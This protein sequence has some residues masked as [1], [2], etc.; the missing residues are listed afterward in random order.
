MRSRGKVGWLRKAAISLFRG[1]YVPPGLKS[2]G[3]SEWDET[4]YCKTLEHG[5]KMYAWCLVQLNGIDAAEAK[6]RAEKRYPYQA[7]GTPYRGIIFHE[8][9][10][11]IAM[12]DTH[13]NCYWVNKPEL[14]EHK[15]AF[16][17]ES[18]RLWRQG[19]TGS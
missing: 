16:D 13:G 9:S 3:W 2:S 8:D 19:A 15:R 11:H 17:E 12:L 1:L 18:E 5:R 7:P 6:A 10:F 4:D 14:L